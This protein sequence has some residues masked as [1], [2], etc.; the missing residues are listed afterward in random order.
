MG[1]G[2]YI[3]DVLEE[4]EITASAPCRLDVGGTWD[5][6]AF[7]LPLALLPPVTT[8]IAISMRM[9]AHL[10]PYREG[11]VKVSDESGA[12]AF[13][14]EDAS[15]NSRFGLFLAVIS[16]FG[17][18]G[19]ELSFSYGAPPR[20]GLGGSG[21]LTVAAMG[22]LAEVKRRVTGDE[23]SKEDLVRLAHDIEDGLRFSFTGMQDQAAAAYGG[24]SR[25]IWKYFSPGEKFEREEV[26]PKDL[27]GELES[28][29]VVAYQ[30]IRHESSDVNEKQVECFITG[31]TRRE[32]LRINEIASDFAD[33]L[34]NLDWKSAV[35][36]L[37]D[38]S[39]IRATLVPGRVTTLAWEL[40]DIASE[41]GCGFAAAGAGGGG[42]VWALC[43]DPELAEE[44]KMRWRKKLGRVKDGKVLPVG[45]DGQGLEVRAIRRKA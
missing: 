2:K 15:L 23:L 6:K 37:N 25:W 28:R 44:L 32:W 10:G 35:E 27:Y 20:S 1:F 13:P 24:V 12:E 19:L 14:L 8:N 9:K 4:N 42:C 3:G 41:L 29:L 43:P 17:F 34:S 16:F 45:I 5:L 33:A 31:E 38:E 22:A 39:L 36:M 7:A 11:W 21:V 18:H 30:G 26:F 40:N